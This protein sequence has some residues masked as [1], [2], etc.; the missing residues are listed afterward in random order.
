MGIDHQQMS[1]RQASMNP[2]YPFKTSRRDILEPL[3]PERCKGLVHSNDGTVIQCE[4]SVEN[5]QDYC[6]KCRRR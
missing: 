2:D 3:I 6:E 4:A 1:A 5:G